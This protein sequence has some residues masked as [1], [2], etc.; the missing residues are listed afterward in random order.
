MSFLKQY[1][2]M[3]KPNDYFYRSNVPNPVKKPKGKIVKIII[4]IW[5]SS[6]Q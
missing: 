4:K 2:I 3:Q 6:I 5:I 1:L